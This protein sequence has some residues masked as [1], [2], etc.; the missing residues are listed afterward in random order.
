MRLKLLLRLPT[1]NLKQCNKP[2]R[3]NKNFSKPN[4]RST[5]RNS[6]WRR[7]SKSRS[8]KCKMKKPPR[9]KSCRSSR[10]S[11]NPRWPQRLK[12]LLLK[13]RSKRLS[14]IKKPQNLPLLKLRSRH[15]QR[16]TK[17]CSKPRQRPLQLREPNSRRSVSRLL[18]KLRSSSNIRKVKRSL[19]RPMTFARP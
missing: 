19:R 14:Q 5:R 4:R 11:F 3:Q 2:P 17:T 7:N 6:R 1:M 12:S 15:K 9:F 18:G 16:N 13:M 10:Q 8:L